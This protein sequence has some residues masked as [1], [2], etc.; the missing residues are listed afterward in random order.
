MH[1]GV[2]L[3]RNMFEYD[4]GDVVPR[5]LAVLVDLR[6]GRAEGQAGFQNSLLHVA[7][8]LRIKDGRK[9]RILRGETLGE[10]GFPGEGENAIQSGLTW[11]ESRWVAPVR[12]TV[13]FKV[14]VS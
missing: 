1:K 4:A 6:R 9:S 2:L 12:E 5:C 8:C 10:E 7:A 11:A 13:L 3:V 14:L